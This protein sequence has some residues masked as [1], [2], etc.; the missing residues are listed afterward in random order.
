MKKMETGTEIG[1]V[2]VA[3]G[4]STRMRQFKQLMKVGEMTMAERVIDNFKRAGVGEIVMVTGYRAGL[5]EKA[6]SGSGITFLHND[7][8]ETTEMFDSAKIGLAYLKNRCRRVL[9]CPV[10]IPFFTVET[11]GRVME[12]DALLACP[13][14]RGRTGHPIAI[15]A[16]LIPALLE[17]RGEGGLKGAID[18]LGVETDLIDVDDPGALMDADTKE[19]FRKLV[20]LHNARAVRPQAEVFLENGKLFFNKGTVSLLRNIQ[21]L[22]SVREACEKTGIS[23][24]KGWSVLHQAEEGLGYRIVERQTGGRDGGMSY[25]T[26]EGWDLVKKYE[27]FAKEVQDFAEVKYKELFAAEPCLGREQD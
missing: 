11:V 25:V 27:R 16:R 13:V 10:D 4:M 26:E 1:A 21:S 18:D 23:Y 6:L 19:D 7:S 14:C 9:F 8:Y 17:Y 24:S 2:I 20:D 12:S 3:A 22:G 5:L 15:D